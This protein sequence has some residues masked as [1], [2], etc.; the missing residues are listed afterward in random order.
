[1]WFKPT[2]LKS[3]VK[4]RAWCPKFATGLNVCFTTISSHFFGNYMN[5]FHKT[6]VKTVILRC[7]TGLKLNWFKRY[8]TN[9]K[10]AKKKLHKWGVFYKIKKWKR[11]YFCVIPFEPIKFLTCSAPQNDRL[12]FSFVKDIH[13]VGEKMARNGRKTDI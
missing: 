2:Y 7:W 10:N 12:N 13:V 1:M 5:I 6:E 8:D 4:D 3:F 11:K 9:A